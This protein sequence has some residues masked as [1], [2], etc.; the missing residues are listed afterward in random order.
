M[1]KADILI[2]EDETSIMTLIQFTLEQAGFDVRCAENIRQARK[3]IDEKLPDLILLDWMLPDISG[4]EFTKELRANNRTQ[5]LP[6]ILLTARSDETDKEQGLNIGADDYVTKPFSPRELVARIKAFL[7]R[8]HPHKTEQLIEIKGL[9][10]DP[11]NKIVIGDG[12]TLNLGA[13]EFRLLHFFITHPNRLYSRSQLLDFVWGDHIFME[14]RTI[15]VHIRRLRQAL[16]P[17]K[18]DGL[19]QT[20]RGS[21]YRFNVENK[22]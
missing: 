22:I 11:V 8:H 1:S 16:E 18:L 3:L 14:E 21:G 7:R 15:D 10:L 4:V 2:V 20:I 19:L 9:S 13:T 17:A 12:I 5:Y 6:I